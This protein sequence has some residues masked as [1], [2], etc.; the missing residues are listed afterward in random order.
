LGCIC[1]N[2]RVSSGSSRQRC[3]LGGGGWRVV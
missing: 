2:A 1:G 3:N